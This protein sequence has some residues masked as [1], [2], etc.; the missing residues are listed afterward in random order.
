[1]DKA[2]FEPLYTA[3]Q[4]RA[5]DRCAIDEHG[6]P[7]ITLMS[8]AAN[9]AFDC[10]VSTWADPECVQVFCGTG[11]NG[12]DGFLIADLAHKRGIPTRVLQLGDPA[13]IGGDALL[14]RNQ[15]LANGVEMLAF[16]AAAVMPRGV[17]VDAMLGTGLGGEVRGAYV[18]AIA[19]INGAGAAVLAVDI[20]SGLCSDS[21]RV[22]GRAVRADLTVS[23]IGLKRG[24]FT[25][26]AMDHTGELQFADLGVP[27]PVYQQVPCDSYR[28]ELASLLEMQPP[29]PATAHK[30]LYGTVLVIGGDYGMAGAAAL[31]AEA[32][33]RCGA[34]LVKVATRPEHVAALVARAPEVMA[35]GVES[36]ADLEPL[37]A[38]A[39]V[40]VVGPGLGQSAWAQY[41]FQAAMDSARPLVLDADGLNLLAAGNL[42]VRP[43]TVITPHPGEAAR[44]LSCSTAAIQA[45]RFA[46]CRALQDATGAVAVLK[47]NGTLIA[48]AGQLLLSDY[49]NPGM[50]SGGMGDV[51]SGVIGSLLAQGLE[52]LAAAAL[53]VCLHGAAA[54][55]AAEEGMCGLLASDLMPWLRELLG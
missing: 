6:I 12:G 55:M 44:L 54:D 24:L 53:G 22:L 29:R 27:P 11:N 9:A 8:R 25:L 17:L 33:L 40:L 32:A 49:G 37:L 34:G 45:D 7:G 36:G 3:Q 2:S 16:E 19:A 51:L 20:P 26:D 38:T 18:E 15:A 10:L 21:G 42:G 48:D 14:A 41:L 39:D 31:A 30:G 35:R 46:A 1:M 43:G 5:L 52:P 50:A 4:S 47:G 23:F 28:L 13:K